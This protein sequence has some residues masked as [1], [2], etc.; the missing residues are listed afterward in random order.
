MR[1]GVIGTHDHVGE[2]VAVDVPGR[3]HRAATA[4]IRRRAA[5]LEPGAAVERGQ[6]DIGGEARGLAEHHVTRARVREARVVAYGADDQVG[7]AIA[8]DVAG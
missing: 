4:V 1:I 2:S 7:E 6:V 3:G 8:V 5:E